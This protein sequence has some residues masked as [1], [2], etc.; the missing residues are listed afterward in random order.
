[1]PSAGAPTSWCA[2]RR[3]SPAAWSQSASACRMHR[4][5]PGRGAA[6]TRCD[7]WSQ[8]SWTSGAASSGCRRIHRRRWCIGS[9]TWG[10]RLRD[11]TVAT[12]IRRR[13]T[14]FGTRTREPD[15][16]RGRRGWTRR[17]IGPWCWRAWGPSTMR[18]RGSSRRSSRRSPISRSRWSRPSVA[19]RIWPVL[20]SRPRMCG[21]STTCRRSPFSR[22]RPPSSPTAASTAPRRR[23]RSGSRSSSSPSAATSRTPRSASRCSVLGA[24]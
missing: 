22:R 12:C 1:M 3:S 10:S 4:W 13:R 19:I 21:W 17:A 5:R 2:R 18:R 11:G 16:S 8:M 6:S 14:S 7:S 15:R 20:V 23:S 9:C 24:R